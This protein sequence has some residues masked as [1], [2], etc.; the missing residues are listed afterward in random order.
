MKE[1]QEKTIYQ[2]LGGKK[3]VDAAVEIFY[4]KVMA[5]ESIN[6]FFAGTDWEQQ[7]G[8]QKAFLAKA[9]GGAVK[10]SGKNLREAHAHLDAKG[11]NKDHFDAVIGHLESTLTELKVP[12]TLRNAALAV[13]KKT[14][15]DVLGKNANEK[16]NKMI[17]TNGNGSTKAGNKTVGLVGNEQGNVLEILE[18]AVDSVVTINANKEI[19]FYNNAAERMFGYTRQEVI[20]KNVKMIVPLEHR[21]NH[22]NYV[23]ANMTTGVN[24]VVGKGRDLEMVRKDGSK[25]WG[26]LSLSKVQ[27]GHELQYTAF[28]KDISE[29]VR[30]RETTIQIL[31][32][33]VDSVV[34]IN[35]DKIITF[36]NSAAERMFGYTREEVMG[37]NV[38]MIVPMEH[39][40]NH[41]NYVESNI[42]T[43]IN[44]VV[45][46][47]RDLEMTRKDGSMFWGNLSLSKVQ[48]GEDLQYTAFI[49]DISEEIKLRETNVQILEQ[50]VDSVVTINADKIIT[51]YNSAAERM[52]GYTREEVMGQNVKMIVPM[53]HRGNHDNYVESNIATGINK[54]VGQGR[55]LEM[56]RKDGSKFWGNLS[57]SKVQ[58][59]E[60]LQYTAFIKDITR[61][62]EQA[63]ELSNILN[64]ISANQAVIE[65]NLDGTIITANENFMKA[66]G[67]TLEELQG[68][69]HSMFVEDSHKNSQE[70]KAF[71]RKLNEGHYESGEIKRFHK[72]GKELWFMASYNPILDLDGKPTK[73]IKY[74]MDISQVKLPILAVNE[75]INEMAQG[76]L[77]SRFDMAAEGYVKDMGEALNEAM[78]NLNSLLGTIDE[79][80]QQV[81][82]SAGSMMN[83][84]KAMKSNTK[85]VASAI[86]QM[87]K[88][89]QDQA[90][91]TDESST[92][93]EEVM[94]S[95]AE[96]EKKANLINKA[97][98]NGKKSSESGLKI[99]KALVENMDGIGS[100]ANLTS[101]SI[102]VLTE[103]AD[104]IARTLN[105]ITDI[106]AQTNLLALNAAIEAARAGEAGRGFAVVAEEI[107][108]LAEDSRKSAVDIEKIIGDVQKDTQAASKA[109][110]TMEGSV[111]QGSTAS[112]EAETIFQEIASSS[113]ETFTYSQ[114]IQEASG[115]QKQSIDKVVKNIEQIVVVAEETAAGTQEVAS[116]SQE[117]DSAMEDI[118]AASTQLSNIATK[119]QS[120]VNQFKLKKK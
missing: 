55:D 1:V 103:R 106:A 81:A 110:E 113:E 17:T 105:V 53:E 91:K 108:K 58:V 31:E 52:F 107:R 114:E 120:G 16:D 66:T 60:D 87:S 22:D 95:S 56:T 5:D 100:S 90:A 20:G 96:M 36:Y 40:G 70:Y 51:F 69:H 6:H 15:H 68:N 54:V 86:S 3:A 83:R 117:L 102:K 4:E 116:S 32:Q 85:E 63:A 34:T 80:A 38:K 49:K 2:Q 50:A 92:L 42:A 73:I 18:Q 41:D 71:W 47:G 88:G 25:F 67:Y 93:A 21:G 74:A 9:L 46:K 33:A 61:Q 59:V 45:G 115:G 65:F 43:G 101:D 97:A 64:S 111:K 30:L 24:K 12:K 89:A 29:E 94:Q 10:Y 37:Q 19:T 26:N 44:K 28:I 98:E 23:E 99:I 75:I 48:I 84:S 109:I 72:N 112:S 8:K 104:E 79:S 77:T 14:Q 7:K 62:K 82:D 11:L 119:L 39:R 27:V 35:A 76:D 13:A 57:L 78:E 118:S